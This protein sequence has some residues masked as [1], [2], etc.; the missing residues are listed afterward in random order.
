MSA[1]YEAWKAWG[2]ASTI[3][4]E[5]AQRDAY[6]RLLW[7]LYTG[8]AFIG[9]WQREGVFR[10]YKVY[11]G[12][13]Q[14]YSHVSAVVNF[15]RAHV[16]LGTLPTDGK[17]LPDG[18]RGA[19]PIDPQAGSDEAN[20]R[21]LAAVSAWWARV[22]W[23]QQMRLRPTYGAALGSGLT[24]MVDDIERHAVWPEFVWPGYVRDLVLDRAGNVKAYAL[25]YPTTIMR[26]GKEESGRYRYEADKASFRYYFNDKPWSDPGGHGDAEQENPYGFVPAIWD[27]HTLIDGD[28]GLSAFGDTVDALLQLNS[29]LSHGKDYQHKA[30]RAPVGVKGWAGPV[31][32]TSLGPGREAS[33]RELA[34]S[35]GFIPLGDNGGIEQ[36]S[37]D[38]GK[39]LEMVNDI[40]AGI[41]EANPEASFYHQLREMSQL[42][43]VAV[44]RA[45]GDATGRLTDARSS[46]DPNTVKLMQMAVAMCGYRLNSGAWGQTTPRE[47]VFRPFDLQ[48]YTD[49]DLD[50]A[51][52]DRPI[53]P[54]T[55]Q[56]QMALMLD[57]RAIGLPLETVLG[58][59]GWDAAKIAEAMA[60]R[61]AER[62]LSL[63][64]LNAGIVPRLDEA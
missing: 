12:T 43:G 21:L 46:Y 1:G 15:Y 49:G 9:A 34:E 55:P 47:Q 39:T 16:Y 17:R 11:K 40:K 27:R 37:F 10:D 28:Y 2:G 26:D 48:S 25:E 44:A 7:S 3:I 36:L 64:S 30:F 56:E 14:L 24:H 54:D 19:I 60:A 41:L 45:L 57:Q 42:S 62:E 32:P 13:R 51:I 35:L 31:A 63:T 50:M 61:D 29:L 33:A 8:R 5:D 59:A 4:D 23:Q 6:F 52:L 20:N 18:S 22:N 58:D 38:V 53:I